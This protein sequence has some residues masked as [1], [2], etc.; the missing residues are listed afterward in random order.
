MQTCK[1]QQWLSNKLQICLTVSSITHLYYQDVSLYLRNHVASCVVVLFQ[2]KFVLFVLNHVRWLRPL[3][4]FCT[5]NFS[6][7]GLVWL[8]RTFYIAP[9]RH[10]NPLF[11]YLS[12]SQHA[13]DHLFKLKLFLLPRLMLSIPS[14]TFTRHDSLQCR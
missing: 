11:A 12:A 4:A 8:R 2:C 6:M 7:C 9:Q 13:K 14:S 10:P 3:Y 5:F 1:M